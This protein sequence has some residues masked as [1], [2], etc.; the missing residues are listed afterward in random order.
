MLK[1]ITAIPTSG[2]GRW[3]K[4]VKSVD[5]THLTLAVSSSVSA[6]E[7]QQWG[8]L[9]VYFDP[10][11]W[12]NTQDGLVY[13]DEPFAVKLQHRLRVLGLADADIEYS[14]QDMQG[15]DY[16]SFDAGQ[17]FVDSWKALDLEFIDCNY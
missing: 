15:E 5:V 6:T 10:K 16:I 7:G 17:K 8:E 1:L 2:T 12:D 11:T 13:T 9:K 14:E 4:V 3:S